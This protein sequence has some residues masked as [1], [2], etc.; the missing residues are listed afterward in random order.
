MTL[1]EN[2]QPQDL[3]L[4]GDLTVLSAADIEQQ[5]NVKNQNPD[6]TVDAAQDMY[7]GRGEIVVV[8]DTNTGT[9]MLEIYPGE[10]GDRV[11]IGM[12]DGK[13]V[14]VDLESLID[15]ILSA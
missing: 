10:Q 6:I 14:H 2:P 4:D 12:E 1:G 15:Q 5:L 3:L 9:T 13:A 8:K 11:Q 7:G